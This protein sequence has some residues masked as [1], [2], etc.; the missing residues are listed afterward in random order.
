M[1]SKSWVVAGALILAIASAVLCIDVFSGSTLHSI[2]GV[3][4]FLISILSGRNIAHLLH[5]SKVLKDRSRRVFSP[6]GMVSLWMFLFIMAVIMYTIASLLF[7]KSAGLFIGSSYL[8]LVHST[9]ALLGSYA[10]FSW[11]CS[12]HPEKLCSS[13]GKRMESMAGMGKG[14][15]DMGDDMVEKGMGMMRFM[16]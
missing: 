2:I 4:V 7:F 16:R 11:S 3:A 15:M 9:L 13:W 8:G 14:M 6:S 10:L 12:K 5:D 1:K